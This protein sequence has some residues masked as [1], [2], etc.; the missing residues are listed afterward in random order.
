MH[1]KI[2]KILRDLWCEADNQTW[3]LGRVLGT[4]GF[5][6]YFFTG[7]WSVIFHGDKFDWQASGIG[8]ASMFAG[9][10]ALIYFKDK[11]K[12]PDAP[13]IIPAKSA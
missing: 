3:D 11:E 9:F 5:L 8:V 6:Q 10:G 12:K 7:S 1:E 4:V 2:M 13:V